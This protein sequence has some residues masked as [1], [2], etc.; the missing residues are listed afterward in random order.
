VTVREVFESVRG[1]RVWILPNPGNCGDGLIWLG[2][3]ELCR[4]FDVDVVEVQHPYPVRGETLLVPAAGNLGAPYHGI[5]DLLR[6][7]LDSFARVVIL[8]C[9]VDLSE[10]SVER[11]LRELPAH[12]T[13]FAR[14]RYSLAQLRFAVAD[15]SRVHLDGDLAFEYDFAPWKAEGSGVLHAFRTDDESLGRPL[16]ADNID[17]ST[18]GSAG[19]GELLPRLLRH[20]EEVHTDRAHVAIC[21]AM[22]GKTTHVYPGSYHKVRGIYEYSLAG[23]ENVRFHGFDEIYAEEAS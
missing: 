2:L 21:A 19:D 10:P 1:S 20:V 9:S 7:Y 4:Q 22:L 3:L 15:A 23:R 5:P 18:F 12:V 16:P 6:P 11:F 8:P 14:E 13:V 17:V